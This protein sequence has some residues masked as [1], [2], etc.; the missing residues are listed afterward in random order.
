MNKRYVCV[1]I[2]VRYM[3]VY[4]L[5][6]QI[7]FIQQT[8]FRYNIVSSDYTRKGPQQLPPSLRMP[9]FYRRAY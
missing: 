3:F 7:D 8:T 6:T 5:H 2:H 1:D 9:P 4:T